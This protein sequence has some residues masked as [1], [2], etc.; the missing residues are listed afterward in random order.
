MAFTKEEQAAWRERNRDKMNA[1]HREYHAEQM[2]TNPAYAQMKRDA[3]RVA[4]RKRKYG[5]TREAYLN[6][7]D[8]QEGLCAICKRQPEHDLRVDHDHE[9]GNVRAL[10]CSNCN[11]GLGLFEENPGFLQAA[12]EYVQAHQ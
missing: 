3:A 4:R 1:W 2:A 6:M 5:L 9:T 11:S 7:I 10:L 12:I 8:A